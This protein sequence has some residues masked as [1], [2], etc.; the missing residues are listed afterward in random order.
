MG[1]LDRITGKTGAQ[2]A[3]DA[4]QVQAD[5][6]QQASALLDPFQG[7]GQQGLDLSGFLT[8]PNQQ[9]SFLQGSFIE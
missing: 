3:R 5:Y 4:A 9:A 1:F 6:G 2:A 7:I 8:D